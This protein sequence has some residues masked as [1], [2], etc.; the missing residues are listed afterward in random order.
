MGYCKPKGEKKYYISK[1]LKCNMLLMAYEGYK[2][3]AG[4]NENDRKGALN[5]WQIKD[6]ITRLDIR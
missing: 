1:H 4:K 3:M 6:F 5:Q 2:F